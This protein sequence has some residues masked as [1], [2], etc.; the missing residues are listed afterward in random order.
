MGRIFAGRV[1]VCLLA[2]ACAPAV[3]SQGIKTM[4]DDDVGV[5]MSIPQ[6]WK[7]E[8]RSRDVYVDCAPDKQS[9]GRPACYLTIASFKAPADQ[10]AITQDDRA[11]WKAQRSA[12]GM[13]QV[14]ST[15]DTT[16]N[17]L[18][19]HHIVTREGKRAD[20]TLSSNFYVLVPGRGKVLR[21]SFN[22]IN[23]PADYERYKP[24]FMA[25]L[26]TLAPTK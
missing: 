23:D 18:P 12:E 14:L 16:V 1:A 4:S 3:Q 21:V 9:S 13:R 25:A 17:G 11:K 20:D 7:W 8:A 5:R 10:K 2:L 19:A 26:R 22:A 6:N 15:E 24:A